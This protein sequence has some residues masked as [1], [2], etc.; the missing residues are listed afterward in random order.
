[1]KTYEFSISLYGMGNSPEEAWNDATEQFSLNP[2]PMDVVDIVR[3]VE[4]EE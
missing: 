3:E 1:M 2:G 4:E